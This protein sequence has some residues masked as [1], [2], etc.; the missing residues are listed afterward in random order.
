MKLRTKTFS[1][2]HL[3]KQAIQDFITSESS[4]YVKLSDT[5]ILQLLNT[6]KTTK[7]TLTGQCLVGVMESANPREIS[8]RMG[9]N[10][11]IK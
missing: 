9:I 7:S 5:V 6:T 1:H 2:K 3:E 8:V 10:S 4:T 11:Q